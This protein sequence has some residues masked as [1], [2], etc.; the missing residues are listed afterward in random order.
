MCVCVCVRVCTLACVQA[1]F[2]Q[3]AS[4]RRELG[5]TW[6]RGWR[7]EGQE[8]GWREQRVG[9]TCGPAG[10]GLPLGVASMCPQLH[11]G[12]EEGPRLYSWE[13][14]PLSLP[15]HSISLVV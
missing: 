1:P 4:P 14:L 13:W 3:G 11:L 12:L 10:S 9:L 2:L 6:D 5:T 15:C 7:Q 8:R